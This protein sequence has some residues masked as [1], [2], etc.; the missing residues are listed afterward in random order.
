VTTDNPFYASMV[1]K[2]I[3]TAC[4]G[5]SLWNGVI[6]LYLFGLIMCHCRTSTYRSFFRRDVAS[7][8]VIPDSEPFVEDITRDVQSCSALELVYSMNF[9]RINLLRNCVTIL[10]L[11][12]VTC[13]FL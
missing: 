10:K 9:D 8:C 2:Q 1:G 5:Y 13:D 3:E 11:L 4:F 7:C 12:L 6:F